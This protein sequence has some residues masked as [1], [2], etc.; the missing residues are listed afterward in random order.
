MPA[1]ADVPGGVE[2][3]HVNGD[4]VHHLLSALKY[5]PAAR[6]RWRFGSADAH[7]HDDGRAVIQP[8]GHRVVTQGNLDSP[9]QGAH[10]FRSW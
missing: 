7:G 1:Q 3:E 6:R 4:A 10:P 9:R 5:T 2:H 8:H